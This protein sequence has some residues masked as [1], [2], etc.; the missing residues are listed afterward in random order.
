MVDAAEMDRHFLV[1]SRRFR[2]LSRWVRQFIVSR[3]EQLVTSSLVSSTSRINSLSY[4][5][6]FNL[7]NRL[8]LPRVYICS[9]FIYLSSGSEATFEDL[10]FFGLCLYDVALRSNVTSGSY[11]KLVSLC[12]IAKCSLCTTLLLH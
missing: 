12:E 4:S 1:T 2:H 6:W 10:L 7:P 9:L 3:R 8:I 11:N 5:L